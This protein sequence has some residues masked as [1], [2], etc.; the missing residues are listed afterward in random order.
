MARQT[1][2]KL[3]IET[4]EPVVKESCIEPNLTCNS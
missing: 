1:V 2:R 3:H 4:K